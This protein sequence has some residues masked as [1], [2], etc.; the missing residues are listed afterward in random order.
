MRYD[1]EMPKV[2]ASMDENQAR[3]NL[4]EALEMLTKIANYV[5]GTSLINNQRNGTNREVWSILTPNIEQ[6]I[7]GW[8]KDEIP[9]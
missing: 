4:Q 8:A 7:R 9:F 2:D 6:K 5:G 3:R 1:L